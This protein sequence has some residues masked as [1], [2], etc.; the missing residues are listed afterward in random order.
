MKKISPKSI[1]LIVAG[2]LLAVAVLL[3][4]SVLRLRYK[5]P[6]KTE[7]LAC[8]AEFQLDPALV[9][10]V[11]YC[12]SGYR[13]EAVSRVGATGLMQLMPATA[14][15]AAEEIGIEG[16]TDSMLTEPAVNIRLGSYYLSEMIA[17]LG[18]ETNALSGYNAGP[19]RTQE[20]I[21]TYGTDENGNLL[22]IPY[23]ETEKY[24]ERVTK[25]KQWYRWLYPELKTEQTEA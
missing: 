10:A 20:W 14:K 6:Y 25:T 22:Y 2:C 11:I 1:L 23:P 4:P 17:K 16:Y 13:P 12:E 5:L 9:A 24:T 3:A 21:K 8:A 7:V 18:T 15:E 19:G